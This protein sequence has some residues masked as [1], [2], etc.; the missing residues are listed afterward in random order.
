M[1]KFRNTEDAEITDEA[2]F[3]PI[4]VQQKSFFVLWPVGHDSFMLIA[5][6]KPLLQ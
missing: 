3:T 4:A 2:V 5:I 6:D 1:A